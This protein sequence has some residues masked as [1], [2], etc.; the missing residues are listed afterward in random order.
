MA[1]RSVVEVQCSRCART[2]VQELDESVVPPGE[3]EEHPVSQLRATL[4]L[5]GEKLPLMV[6]WED[7]C[8]PCQRTVRA[9]LEQI[10]K[11]IEGVSPDREQKPKPSVAK[12]KEAG[13]NGPAPG[14]AHAPVASKN[15]AAARSS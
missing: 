13:P 14:T 5:T 7:L 12:K 11:H 9:L 15:P 1:R 3:P 4:Y 6:K 10:G 8:T 2:E